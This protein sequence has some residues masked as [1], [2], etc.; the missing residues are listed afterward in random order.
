MTEG[1]PLRV[2]MM[3]H[4]AWSRNLG[5]PRVQLELGEEFRKL[6]CEVSKFSYEDAFRESAS[7]G[8]GKLA[9]LAAVLRNNRSFS[10]RAVDW[11]QRH[12]KNFDLIDAHQTDLPVSKAHLGF[13]GLLV[14]RS[15]GLVPE[16]NK[17]ERWSARRW[18][19]ETTFRQGIHRL[20]TLPAAR[21]RIRDVLPSFRHADL[22]NVSNRDDLV[23]LR[24]GMGFGDK[25]VWFP[26]GIS[27]E[28]RAAFDAAALSPSVRLASK[29]VAF[30]GTWNSRKGC[31]DWPEIFSRLR[32]LEPQAKL[33][34]LGTGMSEVHVRRSFPA[35]A[36]SA[37]TVI[38]SYASE[39]L[40]RILGGATVGAFPGYLEGFGFS[41]LEKIAAGLPTVAY[42]SPG[43]RD[44]L[45]RL[46]QPAMVPPGDIAG[47]AASLAGL[48]GLGESAYTSFAGH[49]RH[50]ARTFSWAEI[51]KETL[52][53]Y[54]ERLARLPEQ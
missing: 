21:R 46:S 34:L 22:V 43:P 3:I 9:R 5:G 47:F 17:F 35:D 41:V 6:G 39:D 54:R 15:V 8:D 12:A 49:A 32:Q 11:V 48:L 37:I 14:A 52:A 2:L 26:F 31:R 45:G 40:P 13:S 16:Y 10:R 4:T 33:L 25:V 29:T 23:T 38:P 28:R 27:E 1:R 18:P 7:T 53:T 19:Q 44:I 42:D 51:A 36:Q 24:D 20:M 50:A 30:I